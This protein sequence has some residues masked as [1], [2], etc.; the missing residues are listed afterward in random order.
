MKSAFSIHARYVIAFLVV[1]IIA[2]LALTWSREDE[3]VRYVSFA[4]SITSLVVGILAILYAFYSNATLA[5]TLSGIRDAAG[6]VVAATDELR[7]QMLDIPGALRGVEERVTET[8]EMLAVLTKTT[9]VPQEPVVDSEGDERP[10]HFLSVMS[11]AGKLL[12]HAFKL[13]LEKGQDMDLAKYQEITSVAPGLEYNRGIL[14]A[15]A[16]GGLLDYEDSPG[17][18]DLFKPKRIHP[19]LASHAGESFLIWAS[20]RPD[21]AWRGRLEKAY[22]DIERHFGQPS[23]SQHN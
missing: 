21:P 16:A 22:G 5:G 12:L 19:Y 7:T 2:L 3:L 14:V 10:R 11:A 8:R 6:S 4:A 9:G 1:T 17:T 13:A 18:L 20:E 23:N 15:A